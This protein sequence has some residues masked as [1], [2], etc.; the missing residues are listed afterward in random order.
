[1]STYKLARRFAEQGFDVGVFSFAKGG[2]CEQDFATLF[3]APVD[4]GHGAQYNLRALAEVLD[5]YRPEVVVNQM[6]YERPISEALLQ[7]KSYLLIGC[8]R[9]TLYSVRNNLGAYGR[10]VL[11]GWVEPAFR[12]ALGRSALLHLHRFRHRRDLMRILE[13]HDY[14]VMFGPP[15]LKELEYFVPGFDR[16]K[17][18]LIPNSIPAVLDVPPEKEKRLLWLGR[19]VYEQKRA[20]LILEVWQRVSE[21]LSDWSLDIVGEGPALAEIRRGIADRAVPRVDL[22]GRQVADEY[23]RRAAVF[24]MTSSFEGFPNTLVEAQS[25]GAIPVIFDSYPVA[26]WIIESGRNGFLIKPFD[27][28]AMAERIVEIAMAE[29]RHRFAQQTLDSARRFEVGRVG[30]M[31]EELFEAGVS[32]HRVAGRQH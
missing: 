7:R 11:P 16:D 2:H 28:G 30:A 29:D 26:R 21:K 14:F 25:F 32:P 10:Q 12:N 27:V 18:R 3:S 20:D 17:I 6:P 15:N 1:M 24:F 22:H 8:L 23:Y 13:I 31:W 19:M 4:G 9:N 5:R